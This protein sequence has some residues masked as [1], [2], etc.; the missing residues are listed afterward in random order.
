MID[1][2]KY[3]VTEVGVDGFR[4]DAVDYVPADFLKTGQ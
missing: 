2:M 3:W 1:A 4:V